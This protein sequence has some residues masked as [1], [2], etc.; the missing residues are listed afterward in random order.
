M[1]DSKIEEEF[2]GCK[3]EAY[4]CPAGVATLGYG[5]TANVSM[6]DTCTV[7]QARTWLQADLGTALSAVT[8]LV[9]VQL[10]Q[11]ERDA[12]VD[13]VYNEGQ[14]NFAHSTLLATLNKGDIDG[15]CDQL[16]Q[17]NKGGG[18]VLAGLVRRRAAEQELF[19][20]KPC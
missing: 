9:H 17:W 18:I 4:L 14:G 2:E 13:F 6:G 16:S 5:H 11:N 8:R 20:A 10:T 12:L 15:A 7:A 1:I 3:L 19:R